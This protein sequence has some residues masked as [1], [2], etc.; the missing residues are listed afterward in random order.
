MSSL[1]PGGRARV[2]ARATAFT[3][4]VCVGLGLAGLSATP[5]LATTP[6]SIADVQGPGA[7]TPFA[8]QTVTVQG[9]VIADHRGSGGYSG[10]YIQTPG[11]DTT[12]GVSDGI[13]VFT[14]AQLHPVAIGDLVEVTGT[15]SENF[16]QTQ[17]S[18]TAAGQ[19]AL[20]ESNVDLP[21]PTALPTSVT[22]DAREAFEGML[23]APAGDYL[24]SSSHELGRFGSLWLS[25]DELAVKSTE[26]VD[27]GPAAD[28]IAAANRAA[29]IILDDGFNSQV[30]AAAHPGEQPYFSKDTVVRNGD[31]V[32]FPESGMVLNYSFSQWRFQPQRPVSTTTEAQSGIS[33]ETRNPR[34]DAAPEV[35]GDIRVAAY[36]VL[37]YFTTLTTEN[38]GARGARTAELLAI[39]E[40]KIV[41]AINALDADVVALQEI[42]N[43]VKLNEPVDE[44]LQSLVAALNAQAGA[45]TWDYVPTPTVL[46]DASIVD[47]ISNAII[48]KPAAVTRVGESFT[49]FDETV[50]NIAREPIGQTFTAGG[51][52][53]TVIAN[54]FKSKSGSGTEPADGQGFFNTERVAQSTALAAL[55]DTLEGDAGENVLLMG[56][57]NAYSEEDPIQVFTHAGWSDLVADLTDGQYTYSF[58]GELGSLDHVIASPAM[59]EYV[60]GAGVWGI[61]SAEWSDRQYAFASTEAGT[62][63]RSSDHDPVIV[64]LS[65]TAAPIEIDVVSINDLH[66]RLEASGAVAGVAVL[67]GLLEAMR[68]EN[69][70]TLFVSAG[71]N[72][73]ASTFTSFIQQDQPTLDALNAMGLDLS[74]LGNHEFDLGRS[75][76]DGRVI[77]NSDFPYLGANV[78]EKG[79]K[80]PAY[81][82]Y[83]IITVDGIDVGFIGVLTEGMPS[84]VSPDGIASLDFGDMTEAA[85]RVAEQLRDGDPSNGEADVIILIAHEGAPTTTIESAT[86]DNEFGDLINGVLGKVDAVISGHTHLQYDIEVP[87]PGTDRFMPIIQGG[88]YGEAFGLIQLTVDPET[89]TLLGITASVLPLAGAAQP[90]PIVA[91]IVA[92]AVAF[93]AIAGNQKLGDITDDFLRGIDLTGQNGA[94]AENRGAESTL[95][96]LVADAQL[97]ATQDLGTELALMNPGGLRANLVYASTGEL[98][99][100]GN[101]TYREA[102]NVQPFANTLVVMTLTGDQLRAVLEQQ[103]QP[104]GSSRPFLKLGVSSTLQYDYDPT[105]PVGERIGTMLLNGTPVTAEQ[106]VRVVVNSFLAAGGDNFSVLAEGTS[107]ADSGRIDLQAFVDYAGANSPLSPD[108]AQRSIGVSMSAPDADGYSAGDTVTLTLSSLLFTNQG[109]RDTEVVVSMGDTVLG[110][111]QIDAAV[112]DRTD[113]TGRATVTFEVPE[114][115]SGLQQLRIAVP[116][117]GTEYFVSFP[118]AE[119]AEAIEVLA[120]AKIVGPA[121]VGKEV[122]VKNPVLS[123]VGAEFT[124]QWLRD[125]EAIEGATDASYSVTIADAGASL[126]VAVTANLAGFDSVTTVSDERSISAKRMFISS[127]Q[128][129]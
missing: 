48:F 107:R 62:V 33:F 102:A 58:D 117:N 128:A 78:Y 63:Y 27:A 40:S 32:V 59:A 60:T 88:Q 75:D 34:P 65:T 69:P 42:E 28:A 122:R 99:P 126:S 31:R 54:H 81:Q 103:W 26:Q 5:A 87:I 129:A 109:D 66:G 68:A 104:E 123:V 13:F 24:V 16:A 95:G 55:V 124:Y 101:L 50:W 90:D 100:A 71:D 94:I 125:G 127:K 114:G 25:P 67:A 6:L 73:G 110:S 120:S 118:V 3:T 111:A 52:E 82:E 22:G 23:V 38:S 8:G 18:A 44:A 12:P 21:E 70:N 64:G 91:A 10:F 4:A 56:D 61:N 93:A 115:V 79:T 39:Q 36:N 17:I 92:E 121:L 116:S 47:F 45:G 80:T 1:P 30:T 43:S 29:R 84:L 119:S 105:K 96:N 49:Q 11:P 35:G 53:F 86:G 14:G 108:F 76:L 20:I 112:V 7:S 37:N 113:E 98:D 19:V 89:K 15:A 77:P 85:V 74:A 41:A 97:W 83:E 72:I 57:F 51:L 9:V 2:L 46:T 106:T